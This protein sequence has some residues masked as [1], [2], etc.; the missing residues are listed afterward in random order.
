MM[1]YLQRLTQDLDRW[2]EAGLVDGGK[3]AAIL[4]DAA[5]PRRGASALG[6]LTIMGAVLLGLSALTFIGANWEMIPRLLR[7]GLMLGLL[8]TCLLATGQAF[9]RDA[10]TLGHALALLGVVLF[11][12][13]IMLTAQTF[14][15]TSFRNTA[16]LVWAVAGGLTAWQVGSRPVLILATGLGALWAGLEA[17]NVHVPGTVWAYL[18]VAAA[19]AFLAVRMRSLVSV[20]LVSLALAIW[21]AHAL[22]VWQDRHAVG[23]LETQSAA[24]LAF[25]A[26]ALAGSALRDRNIT[27]AGIVA[28]WMTLITLFAALLIQIPLDGHLSAHDTSDGIGYGALALPALAVIALLCVLRVIAGRLKVWEAGSLFATALAIGALPVAL[29]G[30]PDAAPLVLRM[31]VGGLIYSACVALI[32]IGS[33]QSA[34]TLRTIG[35]IGFVAQTLYVYAETFEGLLDT[36]LF[37]FLGGLLLFG[38]SFVLW[39]V[40]KRRSSTDRPFDDASAGGRS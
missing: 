28:G 32:L 16:V 12:A 30:E 10:K 13:A 36:A 26:L 5:R 37:F 29:G 21:T 25:A 19:S 35:I 2:V 23:A 3:R 1:G 33:R 22:Y 15:M 38:A 27:G 20:H 34:T 14:N 4:A 39:Q 7:F 40:D 24:I 31:L 17:G 8:W 18:P 9:K 11:G 6:A